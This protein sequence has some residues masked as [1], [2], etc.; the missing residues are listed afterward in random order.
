LSAKAVLFFVYTNESSTCPICRKPLQLREYRTRGMLTTEGT[1][2]LLKIRRLYCPDCG[3][4]HHELPDCLTPYKRYGTEI[5][6]K[7]ING[8]TDALPY[9]GRTIRRILSWW[10]AM[11]PYLMNILQSLKEKLNIRWEAKPSFRKLVRAAVNSHHWT[12]PEKI[13]T[14][15]VT[16]SGIRS[17]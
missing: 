8:Q 5:I 13:L 2:D 6:E 16:I 9:E 14:H 3:R 7:I 17:W 15:S 10:A 11:L 12:F 1:K 4:I